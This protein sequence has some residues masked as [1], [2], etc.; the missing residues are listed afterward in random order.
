MI[1]EKEKKT[2]RHNIERYEGRVNHMY[3]DSCG[4]VTVGVGHLLAKADHA[5]DLPFKKEDGSPASREDIEHEYSELK[6]QPGNKLAKYYREFTSLRLIDEDINQLTDKHI[7]TFYGELKR[8]YGDF[9]GFP[10][11]AKLAAFDLI[12]NLG[13]TKLKNKWPNFN[14]SVAAK[15][16]VAAASNSRRRGISD[17]RNEYVKALLIE[18]S[19]EMTA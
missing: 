12:F 9:D 15:D 19:N 4:Y 8:I 14:A 10:S 1:S 5:C 16:W 6:K 11:S 13:M 3:L 2:L 7:D 18:A 17:E